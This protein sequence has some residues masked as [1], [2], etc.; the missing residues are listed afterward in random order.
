MM[1]RGVLACDDV[2]TP[3]DWAEQK[4]RGLRE[5]GAVPDERG[6]KLDREAGLRHHGLQN[7]HVRARARQVGD[8]LN[9]LAVERERDQ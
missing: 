3:A 1:P 7:E 5:N 4:M 9:G 6:V 8:T 2:G